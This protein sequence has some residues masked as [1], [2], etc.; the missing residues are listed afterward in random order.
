MERRY[1]GINGWQQNFAETANQQ[2]E[3][4]ATRKVVG[5]RSTLVMTPKGAGN[6]AEQLNGV[7]LGLVLGLVTQ[8]AV[9]RT[10]ARLRCAASL[11]PVSPQGLVC[12]WRE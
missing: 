5:D 9:V 6:I 8:R 3:R 1:C 11:S 12:V 2:V 7:A 10:Y 4:T